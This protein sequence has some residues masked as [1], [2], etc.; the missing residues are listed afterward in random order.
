MALINCKECGKEISDKAEMCPNC[1]YR[2]KTEV[3]ERKKAG[4]IVTLIASSIFVIFF[5]LLLFANL[6][7]TQKNPEYSK[8]DIEISVGIAENEYIINKNI[9]SV[10]NVAFWSSPILL[11]LLSTLRL[12]KEI[13]NKKIYGIISLMLSILWLFMLAISISKESC[14]NTIFIINPITAL[15]GSILTLVELSGEHKNEIKTTN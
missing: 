4:T 7:P 10:I 13:P 2:L 11:T 5:I 12:I 8:S 3:K 14:C 1:G 15:I 9:Q 6:T